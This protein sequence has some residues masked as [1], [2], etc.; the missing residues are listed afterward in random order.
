MTHLHN[1]SLINIKDILNIFEY[2]IK[3]ISSVDIYY[4]IKV[5]KT[6]SENDNRNKLIKIISR[7]YYT[8]NIGGKGCNL[9]EKRNKDKCRCEC[10]R[11]IRTTCMQKGLYMNS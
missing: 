11:S 10:K 3:K 7:T 6:I 1:Y 5:L 9:R 4:V 8:C 2:L